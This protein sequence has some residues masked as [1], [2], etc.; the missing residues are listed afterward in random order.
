[1]T[2]A[3]NAEFNPPRWLRN[4]HLQ[5]MLHGLSPL[6]AL[7]WWRARAL[8]RAA[9][10]QLVDC[11]DGVRLQ[12]FYTPTAQSRG[13]LAVLLHGWEG[14][15]HS[16]YV[17][18]LGAMLHAQGY[19]VLRLNLRDHGG[20]QSLNRELFHS[21]RL[22]EV[23]GALRS[24]SGA[25]PG[26]QLYLA[27][28][29]LGGN[30]LLR[31]AADPAL[32]ELPVAHVVAIS[33]VLDPASTLVAMEQGPSIY[34]RYFVLRWSGSLR[35]KQRAWPDEHDFEPV[36]ANGSLRHMTAALVVDHTPYPD[37]DTYLANYAI[38]GERLAQLCA[39]CEL[40]LAA[41]D[42]IIP[43]ADLS[44]LANNERLRVT[45]TAHGGHCGF[46]ERPGRPSFADRFVL[47]CFAAQA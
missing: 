1:M 9:Q 43:A 18:S 23:V 35:D 39:P 31:A 8:R 15:A 42:P 46:I 44:R 17:L 14:S 29:S 34:Q 11:G 45:L 26:E 7:A 30:F 6:A 20:T 37:I 12:A 25:H 21:C 4:P 10:V 22:S 36:I 33:P 38:T 13:R 3:R 19:G 40:L 16:A 27:G 2:G 28:F 32:A 47:R 24:I 5:S 41:D